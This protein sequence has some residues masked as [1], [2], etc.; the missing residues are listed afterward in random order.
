MMSVQL[1]KGK[2]IIDS[3]AALGWGHPAVNL[4]DSLLGTLSICGIFVYE[5]QRKS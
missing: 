2:L 3:A 1:T 5:K 4:L